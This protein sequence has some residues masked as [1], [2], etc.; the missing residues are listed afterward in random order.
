MSDYR[1]SLQNLFTS[2]TLLELLLETA[3]KTF[4][5]A[6]RETSGQVV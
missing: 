1:A 4:L 6:C 5:N 2:F 3:F